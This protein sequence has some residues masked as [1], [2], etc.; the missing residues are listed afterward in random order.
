M[1]YVLDASVAVAFLRP[2]EAL[3]GRAV[4]FVSPILT[5]THTLVV[6]SI[7]GVE[8]TAA[9]ARASFPREKIRR[10]VGAFL[11]RSTVVTLGPIGM[12]NA[13]RVAEV[14]RLRGM[15]AI[16]VWVAQ[17]EEIPLVTFDRDVAV[18][19]TGACEVIHP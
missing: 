11:V 8:V 15:D 16:Y 12:R 13:A 2:T 5:G 6:P 19:A 10:F 7:F 18:R 9:L 3:H 14:T 1:R 4:A 17:R